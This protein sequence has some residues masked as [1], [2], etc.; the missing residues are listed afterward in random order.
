MP[1]NT[2]ELVSLTTLK[3]VGPSLE[4]KFKQ[5]GIHNL[6]DLLFHLP[7]RYEDRT[8]IIPINSLKLGDR[9]QVSGEIISNNII[10]GRRRSLQC[11]LGDKTGFISLR[12][13]HFSSAQRDSL[14]PGKFLCC[15]GD[16]RRGRKGF[17]IYHPEYREITNSDDILSEST[18]TPI[19]PTVDGIQQKRLRGF[20]RQ[21]M[22]LL[23]ETY[24]LIDL[25]P[26][27]I[28]RNY[29]LCGLIDAIKMLH[30]P[31]T[32]L[33]LETLN[34]GISPFQQR[35]AFEE[36]LAH[37]LCMRKF[38]QI[39]DQKSAPSFK[40]SKELNEQFLDQLPF[41]LTNGQK[42]ASEEIARDLTQVTPM[43]RLL[44]G[45]VGSG[46][47][48]VAALSSLQA[49]NSDFQV[50]LM[51]PTEILAEQHFHSFKQWFE[52]LG[53]EVGWLSGRLK[54]T[55]RKEALRKLGSGS[56]QILIGTH[57]LFQKDVIY[58]KLGL[59]IID[60][61]HRFG[62]HQ[63]LS[64]RNKAN[65]SEIQ[66]HQL[67]MTA[68]PIPRTLAMSVYAD[69]DSTVIAELPPGRV[70]VNTAIISSQRRNEI[71]KRIRSACVD[72]SQVYWVCTLIEESET[73]ECEAAEATA[74][75]L[76]KYL[77]GINIGLIHGRM[78]V[79][80]KNRIMTDFK[81]G[82]VQLLVATTVIEVG[83]D[84]PN[85]SLMVIENA[86]RLGLAQLHQLRGRV[87]RGSSQSH[88]ILLYQSPLSRDSKIRLT[89]L[90]DS[91]D[92][93]YI[94]EKDL[95][96]RGPGQVLGTNQAGLMS[97]KIA[98]LQRDALLLEDVKT[99]SEL[100]LKN[101]QNEVES[102][103]RR[104]ISDREEYVNV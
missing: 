86:E 73:L 79:E 104:W 71:I 29:Q 72:G 68:T 49:I 69:L 31:P 33:D 11:V 47:T 28:L 62:V 60:E 50:A 36:L 37:R 64:L 95:E 40:I 1:N 44:Q 10:F 81:S 2:L 66:P 53:I 51:A 22:E 57:A 76:V 30:N 32:C 12:F 17:E 56:Y 23:G 91:N 39:P 92:G 99:S 18:L 100:L 6:K 82:K 20:V 61:Q 8:K 35:L 65:R 77:E 90:R 101:H 15:Y 93:F 80:E 70:P 89:V 45:D 84:V 21:G 54:G 9:V 48:V 14:A 24:E 78:K 52:P 63:R 67:V 96:L 102:L 94:A 26:P 43:L 4:R 97:F 55:K 103:I 75:N 34:A 38:R 41:E 13:F 3:G 27:K 98:D 88:C 25:L 19:Y 46:K 74:T 85:A 42:L 83:V 87:G 5:L 59:I 16:I 58:K 7:F